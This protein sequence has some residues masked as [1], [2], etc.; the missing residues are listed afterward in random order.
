[1]DGVCPVCSLQSALKFA[2]APA[3]PAQSQPSAGSQASTPDRQALPRFGD[4]ELIEL[5]A[6]G[7]IVRG[8]C[9]G[10][11]EVFSART[12]TYKRPSPHSFSRGLRAPGWRA[13]PGI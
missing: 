8:L 13:S 3:P 4:Y 9:R 11:P 5:L 2:L 7:G 12:Q 6:H 1:M 10:L